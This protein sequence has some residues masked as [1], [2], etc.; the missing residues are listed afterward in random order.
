MDEITYIL[1]LVCNNEKLN[2]QCTQY[3]YSSYNS[4]IGYTCDTIKV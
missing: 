2:E 1:H 3:H 4:S